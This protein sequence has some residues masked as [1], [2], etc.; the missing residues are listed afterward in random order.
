MEEIL[1]LTQE[2]ILVFEN[3]VN[4]GQANVIADISLSFYISVQKFRVS[5]S[6][7]A[8]LIKYNN[9]EREKRNRNVKSENK[10]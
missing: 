4:R 10:L 9:L 7:H 8:A 1:S 3:T 5:D 2:W 6:A